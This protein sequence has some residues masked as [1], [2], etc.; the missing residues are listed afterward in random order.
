[1]NNSATGRTGPMSK[2]LTPTSVL[3]AAALCLA[4]P[5]LYAWRPAGAAEAPAGAGPRPDAELVKEWKGK[6][7][8]YQN[9]A[10]CTRCHVQP[11]GNDIA[12]PDQPK[13]PK[14]L[15]IVLLT[16]YAI[17]KTHDKH[18]QAYAVVEGPR[19]QQMGNLL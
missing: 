7:Y 1:M 16:E 9:A 14:A 15:N 8:K 5:G 12:K 3:T 18:A 2:Y 17:W 10:A 11:T 13:A 19:G 4:G 6:D